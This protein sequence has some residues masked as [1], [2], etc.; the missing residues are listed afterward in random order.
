MS[1]KLWPIETHAH[2]VSFTGCQWVFLARIFLV[3]GVP[4]ALESPRLERLGNRAVS[5]RLA[6]LWREMVPSTLSPA[7]KPNLRCCLLADL[8]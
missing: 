8:N 5:H 7:V 2:C 3:F 6:V 4:W 1:K